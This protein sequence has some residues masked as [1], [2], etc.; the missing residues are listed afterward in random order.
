MEHALSTR[1]G[2]R[3]GII[4]DML[5]ELEASEA[6]LPTSR[7]SDLLETLES[8]KEIL[9]IDLAKPHTTAERGGFITDPH[10]VNLTGANTVILN[11]SSE[12]IIVQITNEGIILDFYGDGRGNDP[13]T[14][15]MTFGEWR[16]TAQ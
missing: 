4:H 7:Y 3:L 8:A 16:D 14:I 10:F 5:L 15:G 12:N 11:V 6:G 1:L 2:L 13:L 9:E